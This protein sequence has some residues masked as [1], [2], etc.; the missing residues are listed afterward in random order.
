M[1]K[2]ENILKVIRNFEKIA[3]NAIVDMD[4][5][6][7]DYLTCGTPHCHAGWYAIAT[8]SYFPGLR[9]YMSGRN[10]FYEGAEVMAKDLG[11]QDIESMKEFFCENNVIW[12]NSYADSMFMDR[13][14]FWHPKNR[15]YGA[16]TIEDI[17]DHWRDI[18]IRIKAIEDLAAKKNSVEISEP[19]ITAEELINSLS[20]IKE[21]ATTGG[22]TYFHRDSNECT[23]VEKQDEVLSGH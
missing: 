18:Y 17:I 3:P 1:V 2:S 10:S 11:F 12:G 15:S 8:T 23:G 14:A 9:K 6:S 19:P 16:Q 5:A 4:R 7:V 21:N 20:K 13:M 22:E